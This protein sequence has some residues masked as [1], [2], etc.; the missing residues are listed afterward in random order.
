MHWFKLFL[1]PP[2]RRRGYVH[3][4]W[5]STGCSAQVAEGI[6]SNSENGRRQKQPLAQWHSQQMA[7]AALHSRGLHIWCC[8]ISQNKYQ[9]RKWKSPQKW[10][11]NRS[12]ECASVFPRRKHQKMSELHLNHVLQWRHSWWGTWSR[13]RQRPSKWWWQW[14]RCS[15]QRKIGPTE[16]SGTSLAHPWCQHS[17]RSPSECHQSRGT[18]WRFR[19]ACYRMHALEE[20]CMSLPVRPRAGRYWAWTGTSW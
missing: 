17:R 15:P 20:S 3:T 14:E 12:V 8:Q 18:V 1:A 5:S 19:Q 16:S 10:E 2:Y 7:R 4:S 9:W 6:Q 13:G 11:K